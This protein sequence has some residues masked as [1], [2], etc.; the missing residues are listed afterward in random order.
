MSEKTWKGKTAEQVAQEAMPH[1]RVVSA[2]SPAAD[3]V[4]ASEVDARTPELEVLRLKYFGTAGGTVA[5]SADDVD[6]DLDA[7]RLKF[8]GVARD[9]AAEQDGSQV[10]TPVTQSDRK[11]TRLNSSHSS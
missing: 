9:A 11:S 3:R 10:Q 2:A 5:G 4:S 1:W 8:F 6:V 7:L